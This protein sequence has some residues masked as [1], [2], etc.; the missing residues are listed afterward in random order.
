[1]IPD[2]VCTTVK[3]GQFQM[4]KFHFPYYHNVRQMKTYQLEI[5]VNDR[6]GRDVSY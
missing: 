1:M 5:C 6:K 2:R 3:R 4:E